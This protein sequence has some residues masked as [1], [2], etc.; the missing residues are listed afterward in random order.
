MTDIGVPDPL[1]PEIDVIPAA[2]PVP[3]PIEFPA[4]RPAREPEEMPAA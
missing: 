1:E 4:P 3:A 2:D